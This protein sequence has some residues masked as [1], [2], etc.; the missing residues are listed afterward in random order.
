MECLPINNAKQASNLMSLNKRQSRTIL[1]Y[2]FFEADP[3]MEKRHL[4]CSQ[5]TS[6]RPNDTFAFLSYCFNTKN[7]GR[8]P[9]Q[10]PRF[11]TYEKYLQTFL[12]K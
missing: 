6:T 9:R 5:T 1:P 7:K 4:G 2:T 12:L 11:G 10:H 3:V 8:N